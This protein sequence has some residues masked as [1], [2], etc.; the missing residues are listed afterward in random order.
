MSTAG[1]IKRSVTIAGHRTSISLEPLFWE[2][3]VAAAAA[4]GKSLNGLVA[5]IDEARTTNLSSAIRVFLFD[6]ERRS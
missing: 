1:L 2:A 6:R 5:E 4:D 3:L